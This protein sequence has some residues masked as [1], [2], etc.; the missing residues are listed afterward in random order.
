MPRSVSASSDHPSRLQP[1]PLAVSHG[2]Q[3]TL[4]QLRNQLPERTQSSSATR[5]ESCPPADTPVSLRTPCP[6]AGVP[7]LIPHRS[8]SLGCVILI[9]Y[10]GKKEYRHRRQRLFMD[11]GVWPE[12]AIRL[13][14]PQT[15]PYVSEAALVALAGR[16][17]IGRV[18]PCSSSASINDSNAD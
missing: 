15:F 9:L 3:Y 6:T 5:I 1:A 7:S 12:T 10:P 8:L 2:V 4:L 17:V 16:H 18:S 11:F 13:S 14:P